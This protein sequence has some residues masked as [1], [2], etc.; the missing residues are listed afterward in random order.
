MPNL[1]HAVWLMGDEQPPQWEGATVNRFIIIII[2]IGSPRVLAKWTTPL[3]VRKDLDSLLGEAYCV[4]PQFLQTDLGME[5]PVRAGR[6]LSKIFSTLCSITILS[7]ESRRLTV[8]R[9][10]HVAL[11]NSMW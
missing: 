11:L 3:L 1:L 7:L 5:L 6:F 2:I 9:E 4:F 10:Q 8:D